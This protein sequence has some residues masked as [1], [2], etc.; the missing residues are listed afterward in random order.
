MGSHGGLMTWLQGGVAPP[1]ASAPLAALMAKELAAQQTLWA[2]N[3]VSARESIRRKVAAFN[4]TY[5]PH[6]SVNG[7]AL[8]I[9]FDARSGDGTLI[10]ACHAARLFFIENQHLRQ[11]TLQSYKS[12]IASIYTELRAGPPPWAATFQHEERPYTT[13]FIDRIIKTAALPTPHSPLPHEV[14]CR[15]VSFLCR[16]GEFADKTERL[17]LASFALAACACILR[18]SGGR[19]QEAILMRKS[20]LTPNFTLSGAR[21][22]FNV[23]FP[24]VDDSGKEIK[25][26]GK[27]DVMSR[28]KVIPEKLDDGF[29][30]SA[31]IA[32]FLCF[33]PEDSEGPLFQTTRGPHWSGIGWSTQIINDRLQ[34]ALAHPKLGLNWPPE[35]VKAYTSHSFRTTAATSMSEGGVG[36]ETVSR[37]LNHSSVNVT[38]NHYIHKS[39][40]ALRSGLAVTGAIPLRK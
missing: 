22:G 32:N 25:L 21:N 10:S 36:L 3:T 27:G 38:A 6:H 9:F 23:Y 37:A 8:P 18:G 30:I 39:K 26:K 28:F 31:V 20:Y 19:P 14:F 4:Q 17:P 29:P 2:K 5:F 24:P 40:E 11:S 35:V 7:S 15:L 12:H 13:A 16:A 33:A 34:A 1:R